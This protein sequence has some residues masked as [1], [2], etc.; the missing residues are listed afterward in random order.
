MAREGDG[1][2]TFQ[3]KGETMQTVEAP[4]TLTLRKIDQHYAPDTTDHEHGW[5]AGVF[6]SFVSGLPYDLDEK[7]QTLVPR[8]GIEFATR[9]DDLVMMEIWERFERI[10][11]QKLPYL[12]DSYVRTK[13]PA[14]TPPFGDI[15]PDIGR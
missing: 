4:L 7:T 15:R 14:G 5:A 8:Q 10:T 2:P 9:P 6:D 11:G 12:I 13:Q 1:L 3:I